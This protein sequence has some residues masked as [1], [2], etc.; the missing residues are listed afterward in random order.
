MGETTNPGEDVNGQPPLAAKATDDAAVVN[1]WRRC[2]HLLTAIS[3]Y[4]Q[5]MTPIVIDN[6]TKAF[7]ENK[8]AML[9]L[10]Y[11]MSQ[12]PGQ[13]TEENLDEDKRKKLEKHISERFDVKQKGDGF[14]FSPRPG[15]EI[16]LGPM[17]AKVARSETHVNLLLVGALM[18]T[19][20]AAEWIVSDLLTHYYLKYP[21]ALNTMEKEFS[22]NDLAAFDTVEAARLFLVK[23]RIQSLTFEPVEKWFTV[24]ARLA[25]ADV[26][27]I[28]RYLPALVEIFER[29]NAWVHNAG[30]ADSDY[31]KKVRSET[32]LGAELVLTPEYLV[33]AISTVRVASFCLFYQYLGKVAERKKRRYRYLNEFCLE[34]LVDERWD[35]AKRVCE[36]AASDKHLDDAQR[37][38]IKFNTWQC[39]KWLDD[40]AEVRREVEDFDTSIVPPRFKLAR[41]ALLD[42]TTSF[43]SYLNAAVTQDEELTK[44]CIEEWPIFKEM[45]KDESVK[46]EMQK[47]AAYAG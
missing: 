22:L 44:E 14:E 20:S 19:T 12:N 27:V 35:D 34:L 23:K 15:K 33:D 11:C 8:E 45:R 17:F 24:V 2:D 28:E 47:L 37:L 38:I 42:D 46:A 29:R 1:A 25:K 41:Y 40:F 6:L 3:E 26:S 7:D 16:D 43:A 4:V 10:A 30:K 32:T 13:A 5:L 18:S 36:I 39:H 21:G 31:L 9:V